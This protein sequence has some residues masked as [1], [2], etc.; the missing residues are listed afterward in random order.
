VVKIKTGLVVVVGSFVLSLLRACLCC[1]DLWREATAAVL[2][3]RA[4]RCVN[5]Q[6]EEGSFSVVSIHQYVLQ[7]VH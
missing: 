6:N 2:I 7:V 5:Y 3:N 1:C 4:S